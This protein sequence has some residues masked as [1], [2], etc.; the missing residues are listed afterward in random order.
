MKGNHMKIDLWLII[1]FLILVPEFVLEYT[2]RFIDS[3][4]ISPFFEDGQIVGYAAPS[5]IIGNTL[6]LNAILLILM[7]GIIG[8]YIWYLTKC[9]LLVEHRFLYINFECKREPKYF[10]LIFYGS[11]LLIFTIFLTFVYPSIYLLMY[12]IPL[13]IYELIILLMSVEFIN[14]WK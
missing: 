14:I 5:S 12:I 1:A 13:L 7:I 6:I 2:K 9:G 10:G 3:I 11:A 4:F 8:Y